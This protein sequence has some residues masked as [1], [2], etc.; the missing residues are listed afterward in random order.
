LFAT[1][2]S[3]KAKELMI[4]TLELEVDGGNRFMIFNRA[5]EEAAKNVEKE[6]RKR[7]RLTRCS[8]NSFKFIIKKEI[9]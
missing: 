8:Q 1:K 6:K 5:M 2:G 9:N 4:E 3:N 7:P